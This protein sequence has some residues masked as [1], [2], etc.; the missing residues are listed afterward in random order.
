MSNLVKKCDAVAPF[1][2]K[3]F[4]DVGKMVELGAGS[5]RDINDI[6]HTRYAFYLIA[7]RGRS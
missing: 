2:R 1:R 5:Q 3:H 6:I 4:A 7:Q